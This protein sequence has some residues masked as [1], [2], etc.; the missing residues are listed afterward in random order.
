[1]ILDS[2]VSC[3]NVPFQRLGAGEFRFLGNAAGAA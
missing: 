3:M 2:S 1:V